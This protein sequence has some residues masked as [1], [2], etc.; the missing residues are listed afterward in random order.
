VPVKQIVEKVV[1]RIVVPVTRREHA[2]HQVVSN[3]LQQ[4]RASR[5]PRLS[6][7]V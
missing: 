4:S 2:T 1:E 3:A 7:A 6:L 5:A